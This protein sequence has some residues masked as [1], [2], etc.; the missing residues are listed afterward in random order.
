MLVVMDVYSFKMKIV[1]FIFQVISAY[2][3]KDRFLKKKEKKL[4]AINLF[5]DNYS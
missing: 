5:S 3:L 2:Y 1:F 4:F